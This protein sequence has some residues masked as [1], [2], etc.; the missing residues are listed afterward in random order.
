MKMVPLFLATLLISAGCST[1]PERPPVVVPSAAPAT[2]DRAAT[3]GALAAEGRVVPVRSAALGIASGGIVADVLVAEGDTVQANQPL[4]RLDRTRANATVAQA[5]AVL[6]QAQAAFAR[7]QQGA[8]PAQIAAAEAALR[9]AQAQLRQTQGSVTA[10]DRTAAQAQVQQAEAQLAAL[11]AGPKAADVQAAEAQ[12]AQAQASLATQRDQLSAAKT[13]AQLQIEQRANDLIKAQSAYAT[14]KQNWE[15]AQETG[16][17]PNGVVNA[18]TGKLTHARIDDAKRQVYYDAFVQAEAAMHNAETAVQQAQ[19][20]YDAAYQAEITG[21]DSA[22]Q[23]VAQA[24]AGLDKLLAGA[25]ADEIAASRAAVASSQ[26]GLA[27]LNGDQ[28]GGAVDAAQAAVDQ[29]QANLDTVHSGASESDVAVAAADVQRAEAALQLAKA[30]AAEMELRA[31]FAGTVG[32][33]DAQVGEYL[34]PGTAVV[35]LADLS[36][37]QVETT[38]LNERNIVLVRIGSRAHVTF[39]AI[40]DLDL[41]GTVSRIRPL[42]ENKQ[43]DITYVA[44]I[45]LA[46]QDARLRWNM[47]AAVVI[48]Q[49]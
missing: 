11:R 2:T 16:K 24:Q 29:A 7:I 41:D 43:G 19:V 28:R 25:S 10:A 45:T 23:Q 47:T 40:S 17:D 3:A 1:S 33:L 42:G 18:Q 32:A 36:T 48:E 26:A 4:V 35:Q 34:A 22:A 21:L 30:A 37:W 39:D 9:G 27:K 14:A 31:P 20:A 8:T 6:S 5:E 38:D 12:V 44:T 13:A 46:R 49:E 15:Y